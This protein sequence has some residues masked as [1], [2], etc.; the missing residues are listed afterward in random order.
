MSVH[1][2]KTDKRFAEYIEGLVLDL[3]ISKRNATADDL[4]E[5][6]A[7]L[8]RTNKVL[9]VL[10]DVCRDHTLSFD[11]RQREAMKI[12]RATKD[13]KGVK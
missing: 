4:E 1:Y 9:D 11:A 5:A 8:S 12:L 13:H 3:R 2:D 6:I 10:W 7:R